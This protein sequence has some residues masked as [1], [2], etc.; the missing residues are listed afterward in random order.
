MES[1]KLKQGIFAGIAATLVM[2]MLMLIA[3]MMGM[4]EMKIGNMIAQFMGMPVWVGWLMH[5]MVGILLALIYVFAVRDR[6]S[7]HPFVKGILFALLP[8]M[9]MQL[10]VMPMMGIGLFSA[11]ASEPAKMVMGT[12]MGHLVYGA[13]LGLAAK[14]RSVGKVAVNL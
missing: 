4:P 3:P 7:W 5:M 14:A 6:L 10:M 11:N 9:I 12:M 13:V 8:W 1:I 2:T